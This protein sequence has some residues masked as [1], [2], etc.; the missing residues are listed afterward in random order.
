[1]RL[2]SRCRPWLGSGVTGFIGGMIGCRARDHKPDTAYAG[3]QAA[4]IAPT[5]VRSGITRHE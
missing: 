2:L 4:N 5:F 3:A 1:M